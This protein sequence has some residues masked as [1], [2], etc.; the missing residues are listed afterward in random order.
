[1]GRLKETVCPGC[2]RHCTAENVRCK[3]GKSYF[4]KRSADAQK[5]TERRKYKWERYVEAE[6]L[7]RRLLLLSV[8]MKKALK[9]G[10]MTEAQLTGG[11]S[12][13]EKAQLTAVI[14]KIEETLKN[15]GPDV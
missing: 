1:M 12:E 6:G 5:G 14:S 3:Y 8:Q 4:E 9:S 13:E 15:S 10:A 7:L 11:L 2:G